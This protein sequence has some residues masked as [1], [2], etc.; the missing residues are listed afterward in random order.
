MMQLITPDCSAEFSDGLIGTF[1]SAAAMRSIR[2]TR[3]VPARPF[4]R[5]PDP[6]CCATASALSLQTVR[7]RKILGFGKAAV[8]R[9][10]CRLPRRNRRASLLAP[11]S[12]GMV[13]FGLSRGLQHRYRNRSARRADLASRRL[14]T[15]TVVRSANIGNTRA[16]ARHAEWASARPCRGQWQELAAGCLRR[17]PHRICAIDFLRLLAA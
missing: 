17:K 15:R 16:V 8:L 6:R 4:C 3:F 13:E 14:A 2:S 10:I 9:L 12:S 1:R 7:R 11:T 5:P